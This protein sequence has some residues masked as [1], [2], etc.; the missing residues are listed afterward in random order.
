MP[1][2][3]QHGFALLL[4]LIISSVVLAIGLSI[5][6]IS[7]NEINL[8]ST[9]RDSEFA[10]QSSHAGVDCMWYW[11]QAQAVAYTSPTFSTPLPSINCFGSGPYLT[12]TKVRVQT[13]A[14][15]YADLFTHVFQWGIPVRCTEV[16]MY[17]INAVN[18]DM[19]LIYSNEAVGDDGTK[20][21]LEGNTCTVLV[22]RGY[23][24]ACSQVN[25][26]SFTV[27]REITVEF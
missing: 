20:T 12:P 18:G 15:G 21:C 25:S 5:L 11:R 6:E 17:V 24:R 16:G 13:T 2:Q 10:F 9:A 8:S 19:T 1:Q 4:A 14:A 22:S 27:Q 7:I 3:R 26:S 23:N